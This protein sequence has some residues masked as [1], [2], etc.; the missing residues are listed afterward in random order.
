MSIKDNLALKNGEGLLRNR[1]S[2]QM[3]PNKI[4][5]S[6]MCKINIF[7]EESLAKIKYKYTLNEKLEVPIKI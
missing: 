5:S 3:S 4:K 1:P 2:K 6:L 7:R